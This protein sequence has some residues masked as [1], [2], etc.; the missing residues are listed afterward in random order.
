VLARPIDTAA[1]EKEVEEEAAA[2]PG[3]RRK[4]KRIRHAKKKRQGMPAA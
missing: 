2:C 1:R 3:D 4:S